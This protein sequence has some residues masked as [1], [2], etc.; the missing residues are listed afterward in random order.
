MFCAGGPDPAFTKG[1]K[2]STAI[3]KLAACLI[4]IQFAIFPAVAQSA[5][6]T[7]KIVHIALKPEAPTKKSQAKS[8]LPAPK[9]V[10]FHPIQK[11][12]DEIEVEPLK[13]GQKTASYGLKKLKKSKSTL[14]TIASVSPSKMNRNRIG[15]AMPE[16]VILPEVIHVGRQEVQNYLRDMSSEDLE[17]AQEIDGSL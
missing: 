8:Q 9:I 1:M 13:P 12:S 5:G 15:M 11:A 14:R 7:K 10:D 6:R 4:L 2:S 16:K 17:L 3:T